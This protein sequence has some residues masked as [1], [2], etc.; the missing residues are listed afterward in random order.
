VTTWK[1]WKT[2]HPDTLVLTENTGFD[3]DYTRSPYPG[4]EDALRVWFPLAAES[5][6]F[7]SKKYVFGIE[8]NGEFIAVPKDEFKSV[9]SDTVQ[10]GGAT[11]R[12]EYDDL[13]DVIHAFIGEQEI[14]SIQMYWFAWY[15]YYPST[16]VWSAESE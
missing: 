5:D 12:L 16:S 6:T 4:Y 9:G 3:R 14:P 1:Q 10:L 8:N 11:V 2:A 15:A 13:L 7:H